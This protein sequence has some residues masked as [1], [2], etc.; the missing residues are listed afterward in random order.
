M[1]ALK[2]EDLKELISEQKGICVSLYMH[3][4]RAGSETQQD[5]IRLKNLLKEAEEG[6]I[7]AGLR[8]PEADGLLKPAKDLL[9]DG[10]FW[11]HQSDG[12]VIFLSQDFFRFYRVPAE[13]PDIAVVTGRFHL[14]PLLSY[15]SGDGRF[16]VLALS[17]NEVR[18]YDGS[19]FSLSGVDL[20]GMPR[21]LSDALR[22]DD[23]EK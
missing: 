8:T 18:L 10:L 12:L 15:F 21:S 17:Q 1:K 6:L 2:R 3:T 4:H 16:Y 7:R 13:F 5:P 23:P 20:E 19:R 9:L 14:K 11:K 22:Y